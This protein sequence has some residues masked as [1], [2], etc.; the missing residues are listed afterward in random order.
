MDQNPLEKFYKQYNWHIAHVRG[1]VL[2][3]CITMERL[4]D[5]YISDYFCPEPNKKAE[6]MD[7]V[8]CTKRITFES[9][10]QIL[11]CILDKKDL[12]NKKENKKIFND[13]IDIAEKRNM[14]AHYMSDATDQAIINYLNDKE[15][16]TL[17]KFD[18][19]RESQVFK[20]SDIEALLTAYT[21]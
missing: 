12:N 17:L 21:K 6:L 18:K 11:R 20:R 9:K 8:I 2:G 16:I 7:I 14:L 19:I 3:E 15:T 5:E 13:L 10:A 4:M 1:A